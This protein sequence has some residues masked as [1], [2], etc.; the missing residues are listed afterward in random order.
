M[1]LSH[2]YSTHRDSDLIQFICISACLW[3]W[4]K[5]CSTTVWNDG[6]CFWSH[7]GTCDPGFL[8]SHG[9]KSS[10][11]LRHSLVGQ[12][13]QKASVKIWTS[14]LIWCLWKMEATCDFH[15]C[16]IWTFLLIH[17]FVRY[18]VLFSSSRLIQIYWMEKFSST[19]LN[20]DEICC[21]YLLYVHEKRSN[22]N[23]AGVT[24]SLA[25][26][27]GDAVL[28]PL[29]FNLQ[30]RPA[31]CWCVNNSVKNLKP[32][33][34]CSSRKERMFPADRFI[35]NNGWHF[36]R[37]T[38]WRRVCRIQSSC[39]ATALTPTP[40][41]FQSEWDLPHLSVWTKPPRRFSPNQT[42]PTL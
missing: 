26:C 13:V 3:T 38:K 22:L 36:C 28:P 40:P 25:C 42:Y 5:H 41:T 23:S 2:L 27:R 16:T 8:N 10:T 6:V 7:G 35:S 17:S 19:S 31:L 14:R 24:D 29:V 18:S 34:N 30:T 11:Q 12:Y 1:K 9:F 32:P 21:V 15:S 4:T 39:R 37:Q 33:I 20:L